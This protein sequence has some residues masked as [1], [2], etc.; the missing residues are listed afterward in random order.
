MCT[1]IQGLWSFTKQW[2]AVPYILATPSQVTAALVCDIAAAAHKKGEAVDISKA[3]ITADLTFSLVTKNSAGVSL[4]I[5]AIPVFTGAS[6]APSLSL[7]GMTGQT[8][9][10]TSSIIVDPAQLEICDHSS[11]NDW[12]TSEAVTRTLP[13]GVSVAQIAEAVQF[14]VTKQGSAG[15]KLNIIP[16][17]IGPQFSDETDKAQKICLLF[18]FNKAPGAKP[19]KPECPSAVT[20]GGSSSGSDSSSGGSK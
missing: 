1:Q 10:A 13:R 7:S 17:S 2:K 12:L 20:G 14:I 9:V 4:A 6:A 8:L 19:Q 5:A 3:T 15:L 11:P 18:D 16:I